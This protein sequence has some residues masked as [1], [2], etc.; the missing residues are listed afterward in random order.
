M[1]GGKVVVRGD[2]WMGGGEYTV[3]GETCLGVLVAGDRSQ[4][5][6]VEDFAVVLDEELVVVIV[7]CI[8]TRHG[9]RV[10]VC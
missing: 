7:D 1:V 9:A 8:H 4:D 6:L 3:A 10:R 5:V 2:G